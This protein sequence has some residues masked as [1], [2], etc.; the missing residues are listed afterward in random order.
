MTNVTIVMKEKFIKH[1]FDFLTSK[2]FIQNENQW[3]KENVFQQP[4]ASMIING[5]QFQQPGSEIKVT[6]KVIIETD[7]AISN[8]D[9]TNEIPFSIIYFSIKQG[10]FDI[11]ENGIGVGFYFNELQEFD[12]IFSQI[13][14]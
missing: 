13:F 3:F 10:D 7:C 4:G 12:N 14:H 8:N 5:R 9:G 11:D 2:G 6:Y 1:V